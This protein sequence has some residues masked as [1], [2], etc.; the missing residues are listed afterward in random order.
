MKINNFLSFI[1]NKLFRSKDIR[2]IEKIYSRYFKFNSNIKIIK[3]HKN[4]VYVAFLKKQKIFRKFSVNKSGSKK[5]KSDYHFYSE[6]ARNYVEKHH[7][8]LCLQNH[9]Q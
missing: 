7:S 8:F 2:N 4:N 3:T 6:K 5:I 9:P 1:N